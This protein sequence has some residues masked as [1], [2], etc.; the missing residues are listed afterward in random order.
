MSSPDALEQIIDETCELVRRA[1]RGK[2]RVVALSPEVA[3]RLNSMPPARADAPVPAVHTTDAA[4][5]DNAALKTLQQQVAACTKC[6][7]HQTRTHTVFGAGN[8]HA[9]LVFVGEAPGRDEDLQGK[10]FVGAAGQLLTDIIVKG[11]KMSRQDVF[12][13]NVL[14]CRPPN[15]RNPLPSEVEMCEPYLIRQ[16]ELLQPKVIC[17]LGTYAAQTLLKTDVSISRLRGQ[18]HFYHGI[19]LRATFHPGYLLRNTGGK[20]K[21]WADIKEIMKLLRGEVAP[22]P[23]S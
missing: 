9:D 23:E 13:C 2:G 12:I 7:L 5:A 21:T 10:P 14:K 1:A 22:T 11:M 4:P 17:A 20:G 6:P 19:P 18:W 3:E 15:N 16:L 8:P